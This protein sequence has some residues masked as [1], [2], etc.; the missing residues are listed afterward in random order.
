MI[1]MWQ[2]QRGEPYF[3]FQ[4]KNRE[5]ANKMKRRNKF[6]LTAWGVNCEWWIFV[7]TFKRPDLAR[8]ALKTLAGNVVKFDKNDDIFYAAIHLV[9]KENEAA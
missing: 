9:K 3:R 1:E 4:T 8:K 7:A 6:K 2:E 5:A